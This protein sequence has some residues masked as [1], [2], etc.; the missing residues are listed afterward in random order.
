MCS[1]SQMLQGVLMEAYRVFPSPG[2]WFLKACSTSEHYQSQKDP[3]CLETPST[4]SG[5]DFSILNLP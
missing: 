4:P 3:G 5:H 2:P 1:E